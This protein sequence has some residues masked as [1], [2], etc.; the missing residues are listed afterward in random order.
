[1]G[2]SDSRRKE[3]KPAYFFAPSKTFLDYLIGIG[4]LAYSHSL[5]ESETD[6]SVRSTKKEVCF[7]VR[8]GTSNIIRHYSLQHKWSSKAPLRSKIKF[9]CVPLVVEVD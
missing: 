7:P 8:T 2:F 4:V 9:V 1:M 5:P 3:S 6:S